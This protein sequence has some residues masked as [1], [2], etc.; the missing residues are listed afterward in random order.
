MI[1]TILYIFTII[2]FVNAKTCPIGFTCKHDCV[3]TSDSRREAWEHYNCDSAM[4]CRSARCKYLVDMEGYEQL[5]SGYDSKCSL[6]WDPT[7][8]QKNCPTSNFD[9]TT[10]TDLDWSYED[11]TNCTLTGEKLK[12]KD[13]TGATFSNTKTENI[14]DAER[15]SK[16]PEGYKILNYQIVGIGV[17]LHG[18]FDDGLDFLLN[19]I[20]YGTFNSSKY[21]IE[22]N[23]LKC[24]TGYQEINNKCVKSCPV[25]KELGADGNCYECREEFFKSGNNSSESCQPHTVCSFGKTILVAGTNSTDT[26]C[27]CST[28]RYM[29]NGLCLPC[30]KGHYQNETN[31]DSC[32]PCGT[33]E[34]Q[35]ESGQASC[36]ACPNATFNMYGRLSTTAST[37]C[38]ACDDSVAGIATV[39]GTTF[40]SC[41]INDRDCDTN[42]VLEFKIG[43][44]KYCRQCASI[45]NCTHG[46]AIKHDETC[47][48]VCDEN[49]EG[50]NCDVNST[51]S[52]IIDTVSKTPGPTGPTGPTGP[53]GATGP[54]GPKGA[55]GPTGKNGT[56]TR[57]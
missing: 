50:V 9:C 52:A 25:A 7:N 38:Q 23:K 5:T 29:S 44:T 48:C 14:T 18:T 16:L 53:K 30:P 21:K 51:I 35:S 36:D 13:L 54:T 47:Y 11:L 55:T 24:Y 40:D 22:S 4:H 28:G 46:T 8:I 37:S 45:I 43:T 10:S 57:L 39:D 56:A 20:V 19:E 42:N 12:S 31:E 33:N 2:I 15:P 49:W 32:I 17:R 26:I 27:E 41:V 34:F 1:K 6:E 3:T